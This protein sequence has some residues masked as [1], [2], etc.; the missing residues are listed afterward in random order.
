R[1]GRHEVVDVSVV[2]RR[3]QPGAVL[4][5]AALALATVTTLVAGPGSP[6]ALVAG[7]AGVLT[8]AVGVTAENR[9]VA[10]LGALALLAA[11][12]AAGATG[13]PPERLLPST[14]AALLAGEFVA[15]AFDAR[16]ELRGGTVERAEALVVAVG[17]GVGALTTGAVYAL[18][19]I[20]E[21]GVS[22]PGVALVLVA[23]VA[24][25]LVLR[26]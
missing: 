22:P 26:E 20:L 16:E 6:P 17:T 7:G 2:G 4:A 1:T 23:V 8:L 25:G 19:R 12:L 18:Y 24:L 9:R 11:V 10:A 13:S 14:A 5:G 21:F 15:G 3:H